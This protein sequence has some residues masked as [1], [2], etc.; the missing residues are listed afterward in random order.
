MW[1]TSPFSTKPL[2][3]GLPFFSSDL[4]LN[5]NIWSD[6]LTSSVFCVTLSCMADTSRYSVLPNGTVLDSEPMTEGKGIMAFVNGEWAPA[7]ITLGA[8]RD[9]KPLTADE[10][11]ALIGSDTL[12][13]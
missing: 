13:Q 5:K 4:A 10:A 2:P 9:S 7:A 3:Q 1:H 12:P 6:A 8:W 11:A